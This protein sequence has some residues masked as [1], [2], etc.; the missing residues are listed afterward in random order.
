MAQYREFLKELLRPL[1]VY[2]LTPGTVNE[3]EL[4]ALGSGMDKVAEQLSSGEREALIPTAEDEGL[5]RWGELFPWRPVSETAEQ[6]RHALMALL[7]ID[8]GMLTL[9]E[10]NRAL[11]GCGIRGR[12]R[13]TDTAGTVEVYF[14]DTPGIPEQFEALREIVLEILPCHLAVNFCFLYLTFRVCEERGLTFRSMEERG[15]TWLDLEL[16]VQPRAE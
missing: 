9:E 11:W 3:S 12:V 13:E 15:D 4:H 1:G 7:Q 16:S 5:R 2:D 6:Y 10:M 14:P 8:Q